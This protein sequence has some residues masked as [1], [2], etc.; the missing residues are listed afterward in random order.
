MVEVVKLQDLDNIGHMQNPRRK[1]DVPVIQIRYRKDRHKRNLMCL[2]SHQK[3]FNPIS[4]LCPSAQEVEL[5]PGNVWNVWI[6]TT[7]E[8]QAEAVVPVLLL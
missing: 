1:M 2:K 6:C 3:H 4:R 5:L 8:E 7:A